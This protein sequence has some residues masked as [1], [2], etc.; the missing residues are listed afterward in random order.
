VSQPDS[1]EFNSLK[2]L[3]SRIGANPALVQG[4]G[5]NTSLKVGDVM[6]IKASGT[7]LMHATERD[8]MVP[9]QLKA[10]QHAI[11]TGDSAADTPHA[12]T[13]SEMNPSNLRPSIESTLHAAMPQAVVVHAHCVET[14]SIAVRSD[15][16]ERLAAVDC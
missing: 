12:F 2:S 15:V 10:L 14:I 16:E 1:S 6:W 11:N 9:V 7:W 5:G 4:A 8:I 13:V 3:S